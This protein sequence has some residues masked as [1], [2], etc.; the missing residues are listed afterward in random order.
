MYFFNLAECPLLSAPEYGRIVIMTGNTVNDTI[1]I[2]CNENFI[3]MG[4]A[5]RQCQQNGVWSG[6]VTKCIGKLTTI[7][8][9]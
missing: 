4:S 2:E 7:T 8:S 3:L 1:T 6:T 5:V 9:T